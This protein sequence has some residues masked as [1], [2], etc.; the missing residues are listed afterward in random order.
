MALRF[1]FALASL[2]NYFQISPARSQM[3]RRAAAG[4]NVSKPGIVFA[5][6]STTRN[7]EVNC[8]YSLFKYYYC[9]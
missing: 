1:A 3:E 9:L 7:A 5:D 4:M 2:V 6:L 8:E